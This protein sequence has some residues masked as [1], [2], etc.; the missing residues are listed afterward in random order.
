MVFKGKYIYGQG[1]MLFLLVALL[2]FV[3]MNCLSLQDE[4][5]VGS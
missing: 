3:G 2:G 1:K 5:P 4:S